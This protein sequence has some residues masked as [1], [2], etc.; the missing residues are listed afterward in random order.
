[1]TQLCDLPLAVL[2]GIAILFL[3]LS[4][5]LGVVSAIKAM[6][7]KPA[8]TG[9]GQQLRTIGPDGLPIGPILEALRAMLEALGKAPAW[10]ALF[11]AGILLF[12]LA[13]TVYVDACKPPVSRSTSATSTAHSSSR[14]T[15]ITRPPANR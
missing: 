5:G 6:S 7:A 14:I 4:L 3:V 8:A 2:Y 13:E 10:F 1:M 15:S 11:M 12:W 9:Q